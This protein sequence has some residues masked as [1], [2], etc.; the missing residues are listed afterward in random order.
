MLS[1]CLTERAPLADR[2][3]PALVEALHGDE[4]AIDAD[5]DAE[6]DTVDLE[7]EL[8]ERATNVEVDGEGDQAVAVVHHE[9]QVTWAPPSAWVGS[10]QSM[11]AAH[12]VRARQ[13]CAEPCHR[14]SVLQ[15]PPVLF[16]TECRA[17]LRAEL[18]I[19]RAVRSAETSMCRRSA[20]QY[21]FLP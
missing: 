16:A 12:R 19:E 1:G 20:C 17:G 8:E 9:I 15:E 10:A 3:E 7:G 13:R 2:E 18:H 11:E 21:I 4:Q 14:E 6:L 5:G